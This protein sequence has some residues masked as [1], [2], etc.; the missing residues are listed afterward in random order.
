MRQASQQT[1]LRVRVERGIFKRS[2]RDGETRYDVSYLDSDGRQRWCTASTLTEARRLRAGLVTRVGSG[3]RVAPSKV[4]LEEFAAEWLGQQQIRL[5]PATYR[6]YEAYLRNYINPRLGRQKLSAITVDDVAALIG[7]MERGWRYRELDGRLVRVQGKPFSAWTIRGVLVVLGRV[8][9]RAARVGTIN[10]NPVRRLETE[11]RPKTAR[12]DFPNL[13][14]AAIGKLIANTP[15]RYRAL[16][17]VSVLTGIRQG[18]ALGLRWGDVDVKAGVI[19]IRYQLDRGGHLV[20]PKTAAAKREIPIPSSLGRM[21]SAHKLEAFSKGYA[22][23]VDFVFAS[24]TGGPLNHRNI[25]RRGLE[26]AI[27]DGKLPKI[28]WHDLRHVA[29]SALIAEGASVPYISRCLGHANPAITLS[30]Y[31]HEFA[32]VEHAD[33]TRERMEEAFGQ[34]LS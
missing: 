22:K 29:A 19:R 30:I 26:K 7:D 17:A 18:E 33:R 3:E 10:N 23:P 8:F 28:R 31:A 34:L 1:K 9:G 32:R 21:L 15:K 5:R 14:R 25:I 24:E 13:D 2:T 6:M 11:E 20:E 16:I 4:T 27:V 12:R